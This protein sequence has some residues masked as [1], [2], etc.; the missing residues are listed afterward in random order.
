M[1]F[2][3]RLQKILILIITVRCLIKVTDEETD[4]ELY[5]IRLRKIG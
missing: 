3:L 2:Q 4:Y 5:D 1:T